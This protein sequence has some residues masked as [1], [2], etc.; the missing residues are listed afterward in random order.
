MW[1]AIISLLKALPEILALIKTI[2]EQIKKANTERKV[3]DD[4]AKITEAF[5]NKD[6][7]ALNDIFKH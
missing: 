1:S 4:L 2:Q 5:K 3:K 6:A 7:A